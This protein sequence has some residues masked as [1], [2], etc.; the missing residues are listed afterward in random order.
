LKSLKKGPLELLELHV[1]G[2]EPV[3]SEKAQLEA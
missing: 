3:E 1:S 2:V